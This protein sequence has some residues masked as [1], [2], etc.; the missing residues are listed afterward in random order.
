MIFSTGIALPEKID[1]KVKL[2]LTSDDF[3]KDISKMPSFPLKTMGIK[4]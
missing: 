1:F 2:A 3:V 4:K